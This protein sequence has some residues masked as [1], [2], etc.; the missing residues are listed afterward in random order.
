MSWL[1]IPYNETHP[2]W[3]NAEA[4]HTLS[5]GY[6]LPGETP[7]DMMNR[8]AS[9][10]GKINDDPTLSDDLLHCLWQ[11]WI[12]A[13]S[14]VASNFGTN[15]GQPISCFSVH[16]SDSVSSI[17][18]HLKEVA[19][20]SKNGGGVGNYFGDVRPAGAPISGGGKSTGV[21]PWMQQYDLCARVVSQGGVRRGSFAFYLPIDHPDVPELLRAKDHTKGDP[22]TWLDSNIALTIT[23]EWVESM[24]AG[25][26]LKHELF[27][28][29]L[30][31]RMISGS[32]Y[33]IFI[34][35]VN[36][37]NPS[38]YIERGL[39]VKTSNLCFTAETLVAVAD[40]RNSVPIKDL[41]NTSFPVYSA[42]QRM[43]RSTELKNQWVTEI[44]NAVAFKTGTREV[45]E[46]ELEDGSTFKCTPDHLL[47][48]RDCSW[49]EAEFSVGETLEPFSS[50]V[51][52]F[53]HR[54]IN[55]TTNGH[56]RQS[57]L[58]WESVHG[59]APTGYHIDHITSG[60]GDNIENLQILGKEAHLEK[61]SREREGLG[62]PVHK[63]DPDFHS[64]YIAAAVTGKKNPRFSGIDNYELIELG[65]EIYKETG[66]F[67][68]QDY[69]TLRERGY[70][71]P[72]SF[73]NYRFG[74]SFS[75]YRSYVLDEDIYRGEYEVGPEAPVNA[76]KEHIERKKSKV[77][78]I[79]RNGL[80]IVSVQSLGV[81]DVYDLRVEDNHNFFIITKTGDINSGVLVHN[82][83][84]IFLHTD[85]NHSFVCVLSSLNLSRY[86]E[87][88]NWKSPLSG[89]TVPQI[90]I[91]FLEAVVSEFIRKAKDKVGMGRA[92][93]FAEKSRALGLG[94]MGL[95]SLYQLHGLPVKT[96][97]ARALNIE[98]SRWVKEEAV[99][100]SQELA[101]KFG[102]PEWCKGT[103]MRHTHLIAIA[104]TKTNS[105]ICGAGTEGIEPRDRNYYVA[106]QGKG[107]YV[108][109]NLYLEKIFCERNIGPEV[110]DQILEAKGSVQNLD[111]LTE[112]EKEVFK[113]AREVDQFELIK[114]ASDRQPYV[115]QG[116]SLNLFP[117][118]QSDAAYLTRLHLSAWKM[119]LKSLYYLKGSSLLTNKEVIP[120][121]I[122][123]REG[124]PWC[125]KLRG[126]LSADGVRYEEIT[127]K[128]A[129]EKGFW[130]PDWKTVP[131]LWIYKKHIGGYTEYM[132][133]KEDNSTR[134]INLNDEHPSDYKE[135][136]SCEA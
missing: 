133:Y 62:N 51:N 78:E 121:L 13:A 80:R 24:I 52:E 87:Y 114:Q 131:Q 111:C 4:L 53:G 38:C 42:R 55:T 122:V 83:S 70:N 34:D 98:T 107:T 136:R 126:E 135:C 89:R 119:K 25:D 116:Q 21:V 22:R 86:D 94:V 97:E 95:H 88:K 90:G 82:C 73:S 67:T 14:P 127:K 29:V 48:R 19:Q 101:E 81:E 63:V 33:L 132:K 108:R 104:P 93:R 10:A 15:R 41:V 44:K 5:S 3:M 118:P 45:T 129:E 113:T 54:M 59:E 9:T 109:K 99:K 49:V 112:H 125:E 96:Q 110:W 58:I 91:H 64:K 115:C 106:K 39:S 105:V 50:F 18:S 57:R 30:K 84:E 71:V 72:Y 36:N 2:S 56:S 20:L 79:R 37:Q 128:E 61:T 43:Y 35:N 76:R 124:C 17:Y 28:E 46:V 11:G 117:D 32:P 123:S 85:E 134:K 69:L 75:K 100:A 102:E 92:V 77:S 130:N 65:R 103:G 74:G 16:P 7:R 1:N 6:L 40:G 68:K 120:A 8:L 12:G 31:T 66:T 26:T 47:A 27:A 23:D 60:G